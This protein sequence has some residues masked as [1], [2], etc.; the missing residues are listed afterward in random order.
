MVDWLIAGQAVFTLVLAS[1]ACVP[2][3]VYYLLSPDLA[4]LGLSPLSEGISWSL[5][6][7]YIALGVPCTLNFSIFVWPPSAMLSR[8]TG[9]FIYTGS[10]LQNISFSL[11]CLPP[12]SRPSVFFGGQAHWSGMR[13]MQFV[14][15]RPQF[16][17]NYYYY[18]YTWRASVCLSLIPWPPPP[19]SSFWFF[20]PI[21]GIEPLSLH[22][23]GKHGHWATSLTLSLLFMLRQCLTLTRIPLNLGSCTWDL[24]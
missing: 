11:H 21:L 13:H 18:Y 4:W 23:L 1:S 24:E 12:L 20:L 17:L 15:D 10:F 19:S 16:N 8:Y 5:A 2:F 9:I 3:F 22:R 7:P 14:W 6:D